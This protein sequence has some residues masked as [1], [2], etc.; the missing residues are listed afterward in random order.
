MA[1]EEEW[2]TGEQLIGPEEERLSA[3]ELGIRENSEPLFLEKIELH[4]KTLE[5]VQP[6]ETSFGR[7]DQL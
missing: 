5:L 1:I 3:A 7:F 4:R 6:F 2:K